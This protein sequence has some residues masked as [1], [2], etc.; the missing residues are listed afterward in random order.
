MTNL[1]W[2]DR[3]VRAAPSA[4]CAIF[5]GAI[6][7]G[8]GKVWCDGAQHRAHRVAWER[9]NGMA[10]PE[11]TFV[12]HGKDRRCVSRACCN[13]HHLYLGTHQQNMDDR[14]RDGTTARFCGDDSPARKH[15]ESHRRGQDHTNAKLTDEQALIIRA[16]TLP[17]VRVAR[18][19]GV[20]R[21][22]VDAIKTHKR[23]K[24][25]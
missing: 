3:V 22:L 25:L 2:I 8:Y 11:G 10:V 14:S 7:A 19:F 5:P 4:E 18:E 12:L 21:S 6:Q 23:W 1:E 17:S 24:H 20:S 15:P 9:A 16:S 13:P